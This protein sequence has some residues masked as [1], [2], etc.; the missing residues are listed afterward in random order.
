[1]FLRSRRWGRWC[2]PALLAAALAAGVLRFHGTGAEEI[3]SWTPRRPLAAALFLLGLYAVKGLT[4]CF[5]L[6]AL[7][8]AGGLLFSPWAALLV[9]LLGAAAATTGPFLLGRRQTG[10]MARLEARYPRMELLRRLRQNAGDGPAVFL[11]RLAGVLPCDAVSVFL[12]ASGVRYGAYLPAGLA[13]M[14]PHLAAA[15]FFGASLTAS[16]LPGLITAAGINAAVT[17]G[18]LS[19]WRGIRRSRRL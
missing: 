9:N 12:G 3:L 14:L 8:A 17:V 5:P 1:M 6:S 13:G 11:I 2:V 10:W 18:A 7:E 19:I 16:S 4:F 15:T